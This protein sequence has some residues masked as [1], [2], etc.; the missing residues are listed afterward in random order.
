M[1]KFAV[2]LAIL[3]NV[4][5]QTHPKSECSQVKPVCG[6]N[7]VTYAN[8][9]CCQKAQVPIKH[10]HACK[11]EEPIPHPAPTYKWKYGNWRWGDWRDS[12]EP[13]ELNIPFKNVTGTKTVPAPSN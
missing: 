6:Q 1:Q 13:I 7:N 10:S 8:A 2:L 5:Y 9:C 4:T 3:V 12:N 11:A